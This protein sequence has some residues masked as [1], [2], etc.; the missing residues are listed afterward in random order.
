MYRKGESVSKTSF[1]LKERLG[2]RRHY[3]QITEHEQK[4]KSMNEIERERET[5]G[6]KCEERYL[7]FS[8]VFV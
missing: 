5:E 6:K 1:T 2:A 8:G 4:K 7:L 3:Y